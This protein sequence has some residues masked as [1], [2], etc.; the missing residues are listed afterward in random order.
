MKKTKRNIVLVF[1]IGSILIINSCFTF[2]P[3]VK[4]ENITVNWNDYSSERIASQ[5][6]SLMDQNIRRYRYFIYTHSIN[7]NSHVSAWDNDINII[8]YND[9]E[10]I[11]MVFNYFSLEL[12]YTDEYDLKINGISSQYATIRSSA[13]DFNSTLDR[14]GLLLR[15]R[16][17]IDEDKLDVDLYWLRNFRLTTVS[18]DE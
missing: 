11:K 16:D 5:I 15:N 2:S 3:V 9:R 14:I 8:T 18:R 1:L 13:N 17:F 10:L 6:I 4:K 7:Q 12:Y